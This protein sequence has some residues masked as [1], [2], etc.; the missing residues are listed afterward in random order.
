M[1]APAF[2]ALRRVAAT[3]RFFLAARRRRVGRHLHHAAHAGRPGG[4][5]VRAST[6]PRMERLQER[7]A[8][9]FDIGLKIFPDLD[10]PPP[11]VAIKNDLAARRHARRLGR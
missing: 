4:E 7:P 6:I 10:G 8:G 3:F 2:P 5:L 9:D 11:P 1:I